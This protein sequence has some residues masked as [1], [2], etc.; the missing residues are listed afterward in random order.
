M[1]SGPG[2]PVGGTP[3]LGSAKRLGSSFSERPG[4][5]GALSVGTPMLIET[6]ELNLSCDPNPNPNP[7]PN[8]LT[9]TRRPPRLDEPNEQAPRL[10]Q[11]VRCWRA[12]GLAAGPHARRHAR[13]HRHAAAGRRA[14][15]DRARGRLAA[16]D[17][18]PAQ[19]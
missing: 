3:R 15:G 7:N 13:S 16:R 5:G 8:L 12:A 10:L 2:S 11:R 1:A 14:S 6:P 17:G 19:D 4:S 9:F 18:R